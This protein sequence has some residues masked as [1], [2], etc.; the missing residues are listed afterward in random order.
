MKKHNVKR[1]IVND[2][3]VLIGKNIRRIR[4]SKKISQSKIGD[5]LGTKK[6]AIS[7][8]ENG[9]Q[10]VSIFSLIMIADYLEINIKELF[11]F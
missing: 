10:N 3:I 8:I 2:K 5:F 6:S 4:K 1:E 9:K 7:R 11:E